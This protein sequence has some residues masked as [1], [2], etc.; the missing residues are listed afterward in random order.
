MTDNFVCKK[1][2]GL[3][4]DIKHLEDNVKQLWDKWDFMTKAVVGFLT[5]AILNLVGI[6]YLVV[7][8]SK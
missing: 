1:H 8:I 2:S 5:A 6:I 7:K 3:E 4:T